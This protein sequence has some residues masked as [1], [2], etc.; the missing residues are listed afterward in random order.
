M[1]SR[2]PNTYGIQ[3]MSRQIQQ[4]YPDM[5]LHAALYSADD[6]PSQQ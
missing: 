2:P 6:A 5:T 3:E 1:F 4:L